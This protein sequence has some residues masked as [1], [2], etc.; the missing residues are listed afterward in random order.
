MTPPGNCYNVSEWPIVRAGHLV[1]CTQAAAMDGLDWAGIPSRSTAELEKL[2]ALSPH[3]A[4]GGSTTAEII[5]AVRAYCGHAPSTVDTFDQA[6]G[7]LNAGWVLTVA[8]DYSRL[9]TSLVIDFGFARSKQPDHDHD[10]AVGP[11]VPGG[12]PTN[13]ALWLRDPLGRPPYRGR[14]TT[15]LAMLNFA[16]EL[17]PGGITAYPHNAWT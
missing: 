4:N 8:G 12:T 3:T 15:W 1:A 10:M 9:G 14:P 11:V 16:D 2:F 6:L 17:G 7:L 13:P 5:A